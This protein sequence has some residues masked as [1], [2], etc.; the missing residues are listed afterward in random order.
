MAQR[1]GYE[2][3]TAWLQVLPS[4]EDI[5]AE[6]KKGLRKAVDELNKGLSD[7]LPDGVK[8]SAKAT[9]R[10]AA[11]VGESAG[12]VAGEKAGEKFAGH[13]ADT[14]N[15]RLRNAFRALPEVIIDA[16]SSEFDRAV[17]KVRKDIETLRGKKIGVDITP[18]QAIDESRGLSDRLRGLRAQAPADDRLRVDLSQAAD[19]VDAWVAVAR[20]GGEELAREAKR[21]ADEWNRIHQA[22]LD[23]NLRRERKAVEE[24]NRLH[25]HALDED[26]RRSYLI[27]QEQARIH[28]QAIDEDQRR[29]WQ[30]GVARRKLHEQALEE[31]LRRDWQAQQAF[32]KLH[33]QAI[34]EN[35]LREV[36]A[37]R[38]LTKLHE[39]AIAEDYQRQ[40]KA[41]QDA[42]RLAEQEFGRT[43]AG[44][45]QA[46]LTR[47][48]QALPDI[49]TRP[50]RDAAEQMVKEIRGR[51]ETLR[52]QRLGIDVDAGRALAEIAQLQAQLVKLANTSPDVEV[53]AETTAA[54]A[55][56]AAVERI[57]DR[58]D[59]RNLN[60]EINADAS[61]VD[62]IGRAANFSLSRLESLTFVGLSLGTTLIP[63]AGAVASAIG[64]IGTAAVSSAAG[65]G[66]LALGFSG[67]GEAVKA[68]N[69][70]Q[71]DAQKSAIAVAAA[72]DRVTS[73]TE[74]VTSANMSL[75]NTRASAASAA[76][77]A[78]QQ[79]A[80]AER[81]VADARRAAAEAVRSA[82]GRVMDAE[83]DL[84]RASVDAREAREGLTRAYRDAVDALADLNS[85]VKRNA[86]DQRQATLDLKEAREELNRTLTNPRATREEREQAQITYER[87]LQ[88]IEDLKREG[89]NLA[90]QQADANKK[91]VQGSDQVVAARRRVADA[92]QRVAD[93]QSRLADAQQAVVRAQVDGARRV[94]DAQRRVSDAHAAQADQQRQSAFQ[95]AQAQQGVVAAQRQ[96]RQA[97]D[98]T[99][100]AGGAALEKLNEAMANLT[101]TGRRFARFIF[102]LKDEFDGLRA[103]AADNLLPGVQSSIED[104]LPLLPGFRDYVG[105]V[106]FAIGGMF[107]ETSRFL[108]VDPTWRKFFGHVD[109][110]T[111]PTLERLYRIGRNTATG[112]LGLYMAFTGFNG[113]VGG[114]L[115]RLTENF[116]RWSA[117]LENNQGFQKM[118]GYIRE[119]G[120]AVVDLLGE[121]V[122]FV[123]R[124]VQAAA[125][126]GAFLVG[127]FEN[128]FSVINSF[129]MPVLQGI[130]LSLALIAAGILA[131]N[132]A[133]RIAALTTGTWSRLSGV[134]DTVGGA[135][136]RARDRSERFG[137]GMSRAR[138]AGLTMRD[139]LASVGTFLAGPWGVALGGAALAVGYFAQKSAEQ[140]QKVT[141][142]ADALKLLGDAYKQTRSVS[143]SAVRDV[144]A[145]SEE[146]QKLINDSKLYGLAVEDIARAAAGERAAQSAVISALE[147]KKEALRQ[148][149][150]AQIENGAEASFAVHELDQQEAAINTLIAA[151]EKQFGRTNMATNA[152]KALD[153]AQRSSVAAA[154]PA[155][156]AQEKVGEAMKVLA[157][158]TATA[159]DKANAL[160]M[161]QDALSGAAKSQVE[162]E[163]AYEAAVDNVA[164]ALTK[165]NNSLNKG[166]AAGRAN[167]DAV[168]ALLESS[169]EMYNADI[170]AGKSVEEAT[171]LHELRVKALRDEAAKVGANT[172]ETEKLIATYGKIPTDIETL[173]K[174]TGN[175][176]VDKQLA[177]M[178]IQQKALDKNISYAESKRLYEKDKRLAMMASGGLVH[179]PG[180]STSDSI[181]AMLSRREFVEPAATVDYYGVPFFEALRRRRIPKEALPGFKRGGLVDWPFNVNV[182]DTYIPKADVVPARTAGGIG[183]ADMMKILRRVFPGLALLSGYRP[184]SRTNSGS[185]SYHGRIA[186]D[187]DKGRAVDVPPRMD[188]FNWLTR[189]YPDSREIIYTPA[190]GRQ[191]WNGR[192]H[193]FQDPFVRRT[194]YNHVHWAYDEGGYLPPGVSTVFNGTGKPEPVFTDGQWADL[195]ALVRNNHAEPRGGETHHWHFKEAALDHGRLQAWADRR[196][197]LAR[198]GRRS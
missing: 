183:S 31:D 23:E 8:A 29:D 5:D 39:Q 80:D 11:Q 171:R 118:L 100:V 192:P 93:A 72:Q 65:I 90:V 40:R 18:A 116:A 176:E 131:V 170:A 119:N 30:A 123:A 109:G 50:A 94:A 92:D 112:L 107:Q 130:V 51:L 186:K 44:K 137:R 146:L 121:M 9:E 157:D 191:V 175:V 124:F 20:A 36:K 69:G 110:E 16:D 101:P 141:D 103:T 35:G 172:V 64:F 75:A 193:V 143:S 53:R 139:G 160:K 48:L 147:A 12:E 79:V 115:E 28:Q 134:I 13:F 159:A 108:R 133:S 198:A 32:G 54:A 26:L 10:A 25:A 152:Q 149:T 68:L 138:S 135:M 42:A 14:L 173:L 21:A 34:R 22:A 196:D 182:A 60:I 96:L 15:R 126:I 166:T 164:G 151:L 197:A 6:I 128:L 1:V 142:L 89:K 148:A 163:E 78:A 162:A 190:G 189:N 66:V 7:A 52:G 58:L 106:A 81:G 158:R 117:D 98:K 177:H 88:Q 156:I 99:G 136:D 122:V 120:P 161:A 84:A 73:A 19:E 179:G 62:S 125:P 49:G 4:F 181:P 45:I 71:Q 150:T 17:A 105:R 43:F 3:G 188:V 2:A 76:R 86:L 195:S 85:S 41:V 97:Y 83:R 113:D 37:R 70:Y 77:R 180:T 56:L 145:Q 33:E 169:V 38:E 67:I 57:A 127:M 178:A 114:G 102:G 95:I 185:L 132:T 155:Q 140:K 24:R 153:Q 87:R 184:G 46:D 187:G 104:L 27:V 111:V 144:V 61:A 167:R 82:A 129:P 154:T 165:K 55:R 194:H 74:A 91:G 174:L 168:Q 47:A 63:A 59:G